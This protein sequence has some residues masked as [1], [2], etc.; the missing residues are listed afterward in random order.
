MRFPVVPSV[1]LGLE[2]KII[3]RP[4]SKTKVVTD[5]TVCMIYLDVQDGVHQGSL[6][7]GRRAGEGSGGVRL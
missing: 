1:T 2:S 4:N 7:N 6:L 5:W 3:P